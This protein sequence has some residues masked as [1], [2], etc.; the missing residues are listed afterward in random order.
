MNVY[1][2]LLI[3]SFICN[4]LTGLKFIIFGLKKQLKVELKRDATVSV[5]QL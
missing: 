3:G 1:D 2:S 5:Q 4:F